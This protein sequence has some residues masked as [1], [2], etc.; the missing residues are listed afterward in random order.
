MLICK[1]FSAFCYIVLTM[2]LMLSHTALLF[3]FGE[4]K[5]MSVEVGGIAK[6]HLSLKA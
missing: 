4:S 5:I 1:I 3:R 2:L 6:L